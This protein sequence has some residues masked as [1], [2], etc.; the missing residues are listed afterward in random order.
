M[1]ITIL[2]AAFEIQCFLLGKPVPYDVE[3]IIIEFEVKKN[4]VFFNVCKSMN[5]LEK[6]HI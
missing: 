6:I 3:N 5:K 1:K 4:P 2:K